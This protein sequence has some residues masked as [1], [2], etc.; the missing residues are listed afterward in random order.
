MLP[1]RNYVQLSCAKYV[2]RSQTVEISTVEEV[3][4]SLR[5][6]SSLPHC[7]TLYGF[8][9][10]L[11]KG[12]GLDGV[13][14]AGRPIHPYPPWLMERASVATGMAGLGR[15]DDPNVLLYRVREHLESE[16]QRSLKIYTDGYVME[17]GAAGAAFVIPDFNNLSYSYKLSKVSVF[18]AELLAIYMA[19]QHISGLYTPPLSIVICCDSRAALSAIQSD[20]SSAR[21]DLV[22]EVAAMVHQLISR[23]TEVRFQWVP[24][25]VGLAGNKKADKAAKNGARGVQST[26]VDLLLGFAD[27]KAKLTKCVWG[28]WREGFVA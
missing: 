28:R 17:D 11:V 4:E 24:A 26:S 3:T 22:R 8:V 20:S 10:D 14:V 21:E 25:H 12:A 23:G 27:I 2:F 19:L 15:D 16:Y 13:R 18:T 9:R 1:L 6:P 5:G 7:S